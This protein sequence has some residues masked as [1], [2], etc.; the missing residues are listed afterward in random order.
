MEKIINY[1]LMNYEGKST[2]MRNFANTA[3]KM[4]FKYYGLILFLT[5]GAK[6]KMAKATI[7]NAIP[8]LRIQTSKKRGPNPRFTQTITKE[9]KNVAI[10]LIASAN[11]MSCFVG[12]PAMEQS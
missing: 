11:L 9:T 12:F 6:N 7:K 10:K 8:Q 4:N 3:R 1:K 5:C 2:S